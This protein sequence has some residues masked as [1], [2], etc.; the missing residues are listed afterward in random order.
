MERRDFLLA[1]VVAG[2]ADGA[3]RLLERV[4]LI[5]TVEHMPVVWA[6]VDTPMPVDRFMSVRKVSWFIE[7]MDHQGHLAAERYYTGQPMIGPRPGDVFGEFPVTRALQFVPPD[8]VPLVIPS[9]TFMRFQIIIPPM[10]I[11]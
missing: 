5:Q 3:K 11:R 1:G 6:Q 8:A 10:R 7:G 4:P 9:G 2:A